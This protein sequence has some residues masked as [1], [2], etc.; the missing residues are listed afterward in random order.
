MNSTLP[1]RQVGLTPLGSTDWHSLKQQLTEARCVWMDIDGLHYGLV[2]EQQP[3]GTHLWA[4]RAQQAWRVRLD[5]DLTVGARLDLDGPTDSSAET[6]TVSLQRLTPRT[7][8]DQGPG[9]LLRQVAEEGE[10]AVTQD[11]APV[12]F[13]VPRSSGR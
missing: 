8:P 5:P 10:L 1:T 4:W 7:T 11:S 13:I 3:L 12:T 9:N 2:P 6:I